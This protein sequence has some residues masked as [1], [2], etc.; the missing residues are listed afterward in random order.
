M[1]RHT[2]PLTVPAK[3]TFALAGWTAM[4]CTAPDQGSP[5]KVGKFGFRLIDPGPC[6]SQFGMPS[7]WRLK[8]SPTMSSTLRS[9]TRGELPSVRITVPSDSL[10]ADIC[11]GR[12]VRL[13]VSMPGPPSIRMGVLWKSRL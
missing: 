13:T 8:S 4:A 11:T 1:E 9:S 6:S 2:P 3:M 5:R 7:A 12:P 10:M